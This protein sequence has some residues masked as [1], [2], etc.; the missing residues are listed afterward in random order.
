[1]MMQIHKIDFVTKI[2]NIK[3]TNKVLLL[4]DTIISYF[5]SD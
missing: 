4:F 3:K 5:V 2:K 1:M